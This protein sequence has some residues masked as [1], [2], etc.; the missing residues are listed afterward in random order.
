MSFSFLG[1]IYLKTAALVEGQAKPLDNI[2][3]QVGSVLPF[4]ASNSLP[5]SSI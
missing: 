4:H 1:Q 3:N 2:E 5:C